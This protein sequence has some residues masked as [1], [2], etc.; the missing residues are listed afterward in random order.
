MAETIMAETIDS[1]VRKLVA[2]QLGHGD[3]DNTLA[4]TFEQLEVDSLE[5][6]ELMIAVEEE[7]GLEIPDE[8]WASINTVQQIVDYVRTNLPDS[9]DA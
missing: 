4:L 1:R 5:D 6:V 9:V 3:E 2:E 7:F 8:D